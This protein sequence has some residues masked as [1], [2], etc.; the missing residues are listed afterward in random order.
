[1]RNFKVLQGTLISRMDIHQARTVAMQE[2]I[3]ANLKEEIK[4]SK[5]REERGN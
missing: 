1:M 4:A 5:Q 3:D 2:K